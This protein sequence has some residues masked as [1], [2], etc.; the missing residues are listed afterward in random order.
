MV[1]L[2]D[3]KS[4]MEVMTKIQ[5]VDL[6]SQYLRI[7][8][9]ID[10]AIAETIASSRFIGGQAVESFSQNLANY[11]NANHVITCGNGTDAL[12]IALM[13]LDLDRGDE[14]IVPAFTYAATAEVIA[15]LGLVPI[16]V[17]VNKD[18]FNIDVDSAAMHITKKTK[19][20]IPVHLFGQS[21]NMSAI[22]NFANTHDL[23]IIEDNAQSIGAEYTSDGQQ[24]KAGADSDIVTYSFFPSKNLGCY[25]D[26]GALST[27]DP[28]LAKRIKMIANHGQ[29]KKYVHD[30]IGVNS[31]LDN[32]QAAILDVK[33]KHLDEYIL[34]RNKAADIYDT[35]L[36]NLPGLKTPTRMPGSTHTF[37][38]YTLQITNQRDELKAHLA[39]KGIPTMIY[40]PLPL[41]HQ[42]AYKH[43][44]AESLSLPN[45]IYLC[46]S[47]LS[48][49]MHSELKEEQ[50]QYII[51]AVKSFF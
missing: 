21:A 2:A 10:A 20:I 30:I 23:F 36:S 3:A 49:P 18:S 9:E 12:Q 47:V 28:S 1:S 26:G 48:L 24:V 50:Q 25:G 32:M 22:K 5:M 14:I 45:S 39:G 44:A 42:N 46:K 41:H 13:A 16:M 4:S 29:S 17:D 31:R 11:V 37:H 43:F 6:H 8:D 38:Q 27:N 33:L 35:Q 34:N 51:E 19:A 15:L 7:K 40:Y